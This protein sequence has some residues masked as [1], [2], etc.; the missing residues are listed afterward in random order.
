MT[1]TVTLAYSVT[2]T[3]ATTAALSTA[4]AAVRLYSNP[5]KDEVLGRLL[6]L[7]V[8]SDTMGTVGQVVTR[9]IV[10][11]WSSVAANP[12]KTPP[13][14]VVNPPAPGEQL[15]VFSSSALDSQ[16]NPAHL[17]TA[18][19]G[20]HQVSLQYIDSQGNTGTTSV[21]LRG[22]TPVIV[23]LAPGTVDFGGVG[24][25]LAF[26]V[27]AVGAAGANVGQ[28]TVS[29]I[30]PPEGGFPPVLSLNAPEEE[31]ITYQDAMQ[32]LLGPAAIMIPP[33]YEA[34]D[35]QFSGAPLTN[36][37]TYTLSKALAAPVTAEAPVFA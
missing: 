32:M 24:G 30:S 8:E 28:L 25:I 4:M 6:G 16:I 37:Y 7:T 27:S 3:N 5:S 11:N 21:L 9:T 35:P 26:W 1:T 15:A 13:F 14:F 12:P 10:L 36:L 17:P 20:A 34:L 29:Q 2:A 23:P 33:G 19:A 22:R 31:Q 18:P